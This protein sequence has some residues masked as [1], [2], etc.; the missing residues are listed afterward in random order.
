MVVHLHLGLVVV[1]LDLILV[2]GLGNLRSY[3]FVA[4]VLFL[5]LFLLFVHVFLELG[6]AFLEGL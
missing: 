6:H 5:L 4:N 3:C 2:D 1:L